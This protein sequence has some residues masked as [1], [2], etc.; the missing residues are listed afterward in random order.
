MNGSQFPSSFLPADTLALLRKDPWFASIPA[1]L[2]EAL[3]SLARPRRLAAGASLFFRG[4]APDGI[5]AVL[6][7]A[8][9]ISGV[10][11]AGK[12]AILSLAEP[13]HWFGEISLFDDLPRTH[14]V[15][16]D[17]PTRVLHVPQAD[18]LALLDRHPAWWRQL[19]RLMALRVRLAFIGIEDLA[20]LPADSRLARRLL[21]LSQ[22]HDQPRGAQTGPV[23]V[24]I[25]QAQ[26]GMML[27]LSR[28]T[29]NQVLQT[30]QDQGVVQVAYGRIEVRDMV[31][32][33]EIADLSGTER[34]LLDH[35]QMN[36]P[37]ARA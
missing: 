12:E 17:G 14:N 24:P 29:T 6:E 20:M 35:L 7:G 8:L 31:R 34:R 32:L 2:A 5:Y 30:L 3:V 36:G 22:R 33:I 15:T 21:L 13:P 18:L 1:D 28:Q 26:L 16:A 19:G 23:V 9:R 25:S 11:E 27:S 4:D 10:T 37:P